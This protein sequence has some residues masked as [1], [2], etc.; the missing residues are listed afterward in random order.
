[1]NSKFVTGTLK[2][3]VVLLLMGGIWLLP[4]PIVDE[5]VPTARGTAQQLEGVRTRNSSEW[6]WGVGGRAADLADD[7]EDDSVYELTNHSGLDWEIQTR[8]Q[9]W[10]HLNRGD[11][12][13]G[14]VRTP[15]VRF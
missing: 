10:I 3:T 9:D 15:I 2:T 7:S 6:P 12:S 8:S 11:G 4:L 1:M 13:R 5:T 14:L